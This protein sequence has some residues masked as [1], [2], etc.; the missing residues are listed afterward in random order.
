MSEAELA[1]YLYE[2]VFTPETVA[3]GFNTVR[4]DD[5]FLRH[6]FWRCFYDPYEWQWRD[7]RSKWDMLD[8]V[9]MCRALR[10]EGI[11]WPVD[12]EGRETNRLELLTKLNKLEHGSAHDA[13]SDVNATIAV[14]QM[15]RQKQPQLFD[16]LFKMRDK[17][18]LQKMIN[19]DFKKPFVY[20][21]GR[22]ASEHHKATVA[23]PIA[24]GRNGNVL[25]YDLRYDLDEVLTG[26]KSSSLFPVVK[27]LH[28]GRCPAVAPLSVLDSAGGWERIGLSKEQ[29]ERNLE[30]VLG[31]PELAERVRGEAEER[32]WP[33]A[34]DVE[35]ALYEGFLDG[36]DRV[37]CE[38]VRGAG[39]RKLAD[40]V[41]EFDDERLPTLLVHYKGRN[42]PKALAEGEAAE[43]EKYRAERLGRQASKFMAELGAVRDEFIREEL[44]LWY[45]GLMPY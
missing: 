2:E 3:L 6:L 19:L 29:V 43:W 27:E 31:R 24:P 17:K 26:T 7:G 41:P 23:F 45:Q 36:K 10:P 8:M 15:I 9:R 22:Y 39:E 25:V 35:S 37:R 30:K 16:W 33:A 12:R 44:Q 40:F 32:E 5:E 18:E 34:V 13:L 38:A 20:V 1:K 28:F 42:Y 21:S 4:F 14:A 11:E